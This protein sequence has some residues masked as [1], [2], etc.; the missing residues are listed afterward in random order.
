MDVDAIA[1]I[2]EDLVGTVCTSFQMDFLSEFG[3]E[4]TDE[5]KAFAEEYMGNDIYECG[6]CGWW[7]SDNE[8]IEGDLCWRCAEDEEAFDDEEDFELED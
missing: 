4:A 2:C 6:C 3:R 5:E 7:Q 1:R 8:G